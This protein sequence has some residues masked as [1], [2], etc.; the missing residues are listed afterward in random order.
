MDHLRP[1]AAEAL[2]VFSSSKRRCTSIRWTEVL[3][4]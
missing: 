3:R 1:L 2:A 4:A